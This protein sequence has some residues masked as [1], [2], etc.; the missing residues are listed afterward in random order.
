MFLPVMTSRRMS[1]MRSSAPTGNWPFSLDMK[2]VSIMKMVPVTLCG[3][4]FVFTSFSLKKG[5]F[6]RLSQRRAVGTFSDSLSNPQA[7]DFAEM[8]AIDRKGNSQRD[9]LRSVKKRPGQD[10]PIL[11]SLFA[12]NAQADACT[13]DCHQTLKTQWGSGLWSLILPEEGHCPFIVMLG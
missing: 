8:M 13:G 10:L 5:G 2:I 4:I 1:W 3:S 12:E 7:A 11:E 9:Q 6:E